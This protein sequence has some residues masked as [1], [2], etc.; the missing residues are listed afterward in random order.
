M[1]TCT[2]SLYILGTRDELQGRIS[3]F[4]GLGGEGGGGGHKLEKKM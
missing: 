2:C 1:Y 4:V 3:D